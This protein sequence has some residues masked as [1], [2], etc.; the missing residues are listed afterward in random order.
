[1]QVQ[2]FLLET[3]QKNKGR[4]QRETVCLVETEARQRNMPGEKGCA[5]PPK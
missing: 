4:E 5:H 1:M 2:S 3:Q